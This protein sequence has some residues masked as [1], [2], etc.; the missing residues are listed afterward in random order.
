MFLRRVLLLI[1]VFLWVGCGLLLYARRETAR[2]AWQ[3]V[4][5][6]N[7]QGA[8][9]YRQKASHPHAPRTLL[10]PKL[11]L[12]R[13]A[14]WSPDGRWIAVV[15]YSLLVVRSGGREVRT[16]T[17]TYDG[18]PEWSPD[19]KWLL[20]TSYRQGLWDIYKIHVETGETHRLTFT[21][22]DDTQ[23]HWSADGKWVYFRT[24]QGSQWGDVRVPSDGSGVLQPLPFAADVDEDKSLSPVIDYSWNPEILLLVGGLLIM[25]GGWRRS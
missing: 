5:E 16:L 1:G 18:S 13:S 4:I 3:A 19:G 15:D 17:D 9:L 22:G 10:T 23:P 12:Y 14:D 2:P 20:F 21:P 11:G 6:Y 25:I 8:Y 24:H 7:Q